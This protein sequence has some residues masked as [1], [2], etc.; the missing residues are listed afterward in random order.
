MYQPCSAVRARNAFVDCT[1]KELV[2]SL[3]YWNDGCGWR[4]TQGAPDGGWMIAAIIVSVVLA[5]ATPSA[6]P[7]G[8]VTGVG[9]VFVRSVDPQRLAAWYHDVLGIQLES[10]G[11]ALLRYDAPGH[12]PVAVW[13]AFKPENKEFLSRR[14]ASS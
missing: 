9:G 1:T 6:Q 11:G 12:P 5:A 2:I 7:R 10:W 3:F 14:S 8:H 4:M 13:N